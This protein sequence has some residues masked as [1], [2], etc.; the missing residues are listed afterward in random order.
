MRAGLKNDSNLCYGNAV[1]QCVYSCD[2]IRHA[3]LGAAD[4][5]KCPPRTDRDYRMREMRRSLCK[6]FELMSK[7]N[8]KHRI[9]DATEIIRGISML[10]PSSIQFGDCN[11]ACEFL[12][13]LMEDMCGS[14]CRYTIPKR[15]L[16]GESVIKL[17]CENCRNVEKSKHDFGLLTLCNPTESGM[18]GM[19]ENHFARTRMEGSTCEK[20]KSSTGISRQEMLLRCPRVLI[21]TFAHPIRNVDVA[22]DITVVR[23][24]QD[25]TRCKY[26]VRGAILRRGM[27]FVSV[28]FPSSLQSGFLLDDEHCREISSV[29]AFKMV[30]TNPHCI[31]YEDV[32]SSR[33]VM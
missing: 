20:C 17:V 24:K 13:L 3:V 1:L 14:D 10:H 15:L 30:G 9:L 18:R 33:S 27:H 26:V 5:S 29:E 32:S 7:N 11:D 2:A 6:L 4:T 19:I 28:V 25:S 22:S 21:I 31:L 23:A 12:L 8:D 16:Y